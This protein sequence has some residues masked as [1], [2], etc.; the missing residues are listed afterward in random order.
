MQNNN[1]SVKNTALFIAA[2][3]SFL[4]PFMTSSINVSLPDIEKDFL[5]DAVLLSWVASSYILAAAIFLVPFGKIADIYGRKKIFLIGISTYSISTILIGLS[6]SI[7]TLLAFRV[8]QGIGSSMVFSTNIAI[9]TSVFPLG[10]RGKALGINVSAVYVGLSLGPVLGGVLTQHFGW[11]SLFLFQIP[12]CILIILLTLTKLKDEWAESKGKKFDTLGTTIYVFSL[13]CL[14]YGLT[15]VTNIK[16]ISLIILA[17]GL[18]IALVQI[19]KRA[20]YPIIDFNLFKTN[21]TFTF[22]NAAA[23]INYSSTFAVSFVLS[24]YLHY[25]KG[26]HSQ[27]VGMILLFQPLM[28]ALF[29]PFAGRLSDKIEPRIIASIGMGLMSLSLFIF[30]TINFQSNILFIAFTL[31]LLGLGFALFSSPNANAIMSSVEKKDYGL[32]SALLGTMR[33]TGQMFSMAIVMVVFTLI[34]GKVRITPEHYN[35]FVS[36]IKML[37]LIFGVLNFIGIFASIA[38]GDIKA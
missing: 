7:Y 9:I 12:F 5:V 30:S 21:I 8:I 26:L 32:A 6:D 2:L 10:E 25:I 36:S 38:R 4:A 27:Y 31:A 37:F 18:F 17:V 11:R 24:L 16:S 3:S 29:S 14:M 28:M 34:I 1:S 19:E 20:K 22:S 35:D 13:A 33:L 15:I 23:F